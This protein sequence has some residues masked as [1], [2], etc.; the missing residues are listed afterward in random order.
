MAK[1]IVSTIPEKKYLAA[2]VA[3]SEGMPKQGLRLENFKLCSSLEGD[4]GSR[5]NIRAVETCGLPG[6]YF[7]DVAPATGKQTRQGLYVFD[8]LVQDGQDR[9]QSMASMSLR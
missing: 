2:F 5:V 8:L 6:F 3:D 4:D 7:L 1:L 9:G